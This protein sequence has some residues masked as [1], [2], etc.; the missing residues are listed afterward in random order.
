MVRLSAFTDYIIKRFS[1]KSKIRRIKGKIVKIVER[2]DE[3]KVVVQVMNTRITLLNKSNEILKVG[4]EVWVFYWKTI[5]DGCVAM[6]VGL[7]DYSHLWSYTLP[8]HRDTGHINT[9]FFVNAI[10]PEYEQSYNYSIN[11]DS[12]E[13][14]NYFYPTTTIIQITE[15]H[16]NLNAY[17]T[18][19]YK[20]NG[21]AFYIEWIPLDISH[22]DYFAV[23]HY[24]TNLSI[25]R[26]INGIIKTVD[27]SIET[28]NNKVVIARYLDG[29]RTTYAYF[30][31][32]YKGEISDVSKCAFYVTGGN[33]IYDPA[34]EEIVFNCS[35]YPC[36]YNTNSVKWFPVLPEGG[37]YSIDDNN[38]IVVDKNS[39]SITDNKIYEIETDDE[40]T[41]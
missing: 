9:S 11:E 19:L 21:A 17:S 12:A 23:S 26:R 20:T 14:Y 8:F 34:L 36:Y 18:M 39:I 10:E 38:P 5:K 25:D 40:R 28:E 33:G 22:S 24:Y 4:D 3:G 16:D 15:T 2:T 35:I 6:K 37:S 30:K 41:V 31:D 7:S 13:E 32:A 1:A 29:T 27:Y